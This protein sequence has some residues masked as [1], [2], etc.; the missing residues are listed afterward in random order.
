MTEEKKPLSETRAGLV[1]AALAGIP[2]GPIGIFASPLVLYL[3]TL[4]LKSKD[5]KIGIGSSLG[6]LLE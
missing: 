1:I 2:G 6:L 4:I 5:G 3:F